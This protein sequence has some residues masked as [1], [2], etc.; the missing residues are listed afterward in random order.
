MSTYTLTKFYTSPFSYKHPPMSIYGLT[1]P[2]TAIY[3]EK[4]IMSM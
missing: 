3:N 1:K 4:S 2:P